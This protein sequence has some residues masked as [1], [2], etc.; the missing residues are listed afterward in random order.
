M[1]MDRVMNY[2]GNGSEVH[3]RRAQ[4]ATSRNGTAKSA[5]TA[6]KLLELQQELALTKRKLR[7]ERSL[8]KKMQKPLP[9]CPKETEDQI[10]L[11][12]EVKAF[13]ARQ[14]PIQDFIASLW[15]KG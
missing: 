3:M 5:G 10:P 14:Q 13:I 12:A 1:V 9:L 2:L 4:T 8:R 11:I 6:R 15:K 7:R